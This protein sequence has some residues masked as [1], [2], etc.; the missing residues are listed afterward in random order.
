[1]TEKLVIHC[2]R[3]MRMCFFFILS[4]TLW[5]YY[6]ASCAFVT[7]FHLLSS[8]CLLTKLKWLNVFV[9]SCGLVCVYFSAVDYQRNSN[10]NVWKQ[11]DSGIICNNWKTVNY[12]VCYQ[13][14]EC[15]NAMKHHAMVFGHFHVSLALLTISSNIEPHEW[16]NQCSY[17]DL[18]E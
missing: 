5:K 15:V 16:W 6:S 2:Y 11:M 1:M 8:T 17:V 12:R 18:F 9:C 4:T 10:L 13:F 14:H 7:H 3:C